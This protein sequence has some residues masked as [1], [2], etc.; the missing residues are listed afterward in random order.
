[1]LL[2]ASFTACSSLK[3]D[4]QVIGP[5]YQ[6][7][8]T[9]ARQPVLPQ[10]LRRVAVLPMTAGGEASALQTGCSM[11]EPFLIEELNKTKRF[12]VLQVSRAH[13]Q[14]WTGKPAW[15]AEEP[16]PA[17]FFDKLKK[18]LG[19]DSVLFCRLTG[20]RPYRPLAVGFN[21]KL[22]DGGSSPFLWS[23]DEFFDAGRP[24]VVNAARRYW[25]QHV[26][27]VRPLTD[28]MGILGSPRQFGQYAISALVA[29]MPTR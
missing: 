23:A 29:T 8:N 16:L 14:S 26:R 2:V 15:T 25:Q 11:L 1:V 3:L 4:D 20:F 9:Y 22:V 6:P 21:M 10:E 13:L 24:E 17:G 28:S 12:E 5:S 18:E 7:S 27:D 19:C